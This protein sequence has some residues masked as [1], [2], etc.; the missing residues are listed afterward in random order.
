MPA[1][2]MLAARASC[3]QCGWRVVLKQRIPDVVTEWDPERD[4]F[5]YAR[6]CPVCGSNEVEI[7]QPGLWERMSP[8]EA[9]RRLLHRLRGTYPTP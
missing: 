3:H 8:V 1:M 7:S 2:R 9:A 5:E 4:Y 6:T